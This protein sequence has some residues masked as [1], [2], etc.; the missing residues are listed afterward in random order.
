MTGDGH[1]LPP[2]PARRPPVDGP[3]SPGATGRVT[4]A[5]GSRHVAVGTEASLLPP[6]G[7]NGGLSRPKAALRWR[8][9]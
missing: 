1:S 2:W 4:D 3:L 5:P 8:A 9:R 6:D 7:G